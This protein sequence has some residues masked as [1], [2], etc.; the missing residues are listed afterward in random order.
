[1]ERIGNY[2]LGRTLGEGAFAKVKAARHAITGSHV[3]IKII[4]K[5]QTKDEYV[6]RN[7]HREGEL[8]RRLKHRHV[9]TLYEIL[10]TDSLFCLVCELAGGG[11]VKIGA[12][13]CSKIGDIT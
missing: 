5:V 12:K 6:L 1:M 8:M 9:I 3:A 10:E 2:I 11:E 4:N 13:L 7:L